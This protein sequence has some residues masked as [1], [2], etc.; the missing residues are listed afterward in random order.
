MRLLLAIALALGAYP[1][2]MLIA[3]LLI[4]LALLHRYNG[5][6]NGGSDRMSLLMLCCLCLAQ[7]LPIERGRELAMGYLALQLTLS[8]FMAGWVKIRNR[9]WRNGQALADVFFFSAYPVSESLRQWRASTRLL[10][11]MSWAVMLLELSFP[12]TLLNR[13]TL[14]VALVL[15]ALFHLVN[16]CVFGLNRFFWIWLCAYP[17]LIWVQQRVVTH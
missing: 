4:A 12:L 3:L 6:Y 11:S 9:E 2:W 16:G 14:H 7:G 5:P 15:T 17:S 13:A 8:Y 1:E 10:W